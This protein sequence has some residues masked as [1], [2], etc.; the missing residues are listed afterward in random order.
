MSCFRQNTN[1]QSQDEKHNNFNGMVW[2]LFNKG[3]IFEKMA[4]HPVILNTSNIII[5]ENSAVSSLAA[6]TVL[7]GNGGQLPHLDYPYYRMQLPSSN[8]H[9]MDN[10]PPL[11]LQFVTLLTDFNSENGGTAFRPNSHHKPRYPD[12]KEEFY[13]NAIQISG[14][15]GDMILFHGALQH[16]AMP[17][18]SKSFRTGILQHMAPV[19]IKP[20]ESM[21]EYVRDDIK[22][23][24]SMGLKRLLA[25]DHPYPML[26]L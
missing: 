18:R 12:N 23:K 21:A 6:N 19:Y 24:A 7:P 14:K 3:K 1:H 4:Q 17:N 25:M 13:K 2:A 22:A 16:C 15:A 5:G 11:S 8:P 9:I 10:A 26:K 20:F